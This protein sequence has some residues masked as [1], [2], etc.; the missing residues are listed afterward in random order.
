MT[1]KEFL[2]QYGREKL[3][4]ERLN[5]RIAALDDLFSVTQDMTSEK[6]Q[7]SPKPDRMGEIIAKKADLQA[8]LEEEVQEAYRV[9][10]EVEAVINRLQDERQKALLHDRYILLWKWRKIEDRLGF[11]SNQ[12]WVYVLHKRAL[13]EVERIINEIQS[14]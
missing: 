12:R 8:D 9:M 6:V 7:S 2:R 3:K 11:D 13:R 4:I 10:N 14:V 1:A 5:D